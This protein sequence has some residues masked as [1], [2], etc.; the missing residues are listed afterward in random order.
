MA[1]QISLFADAGQGVGAGHI[2][3]VYSVFRRLRAM[4]IASRMFVSLPEQELRGLGLLGVS[5]APADIADAISLLLST[6][7]VVALLD[8]YRDVPQWLDR[9]GS[10]SVLIGMFDDH[11]LI[12]R[13][14]AIIVNANPEISVEDYAEE[15]ATTYLLGPSFASL[16]EGF[17]RG[18]RPYVVRSIVSRVLLALGGDDSQG[19]LSAYVEATAAAFRHPIAL[20]VVGSRS[21]SLDVAAHVQL[22]FGW[23]NQHQL[24]ERMQSADLAMIGGGSMIL[25]TSC[26]GIPTLCWPQ[27]PKQAQHALAWQAKGAVVVMS[28]LDDLANVVLD[29]MPEQRRRQL[30][31]SARILVDGLGAQRI[32]DCLLA[33]LGA[34]HAN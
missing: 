22:D 20:Q 10:N 30:S 31:E 29:V 14:V 19:N 15:L 26:I 13:P 3:R 16:S 8:T 7:P 21:I 17:L 1:M 25:Q 28:S 34:D 6:R 2:F 23:V 27:D 9:L 12:D 18:R 24:V 11:F 4:G 32:A 33:T 5:S